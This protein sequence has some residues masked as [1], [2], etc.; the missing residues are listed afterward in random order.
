[1][2]QITREAW[3]S[4]VSKLMDM[5]SDKRKHFAMLLMNLADCYVDGGDS[6]AVV[7]VHNDD[8]LLTFCA[9]ATE[10]EAYEIIQ[11]AQKTLEHVVTAD[12]PAKELFN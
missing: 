4:T 10:F 9:G 12:A 3:E 6:A 5:P 8:E 11:R 7:L 2:D 1:M